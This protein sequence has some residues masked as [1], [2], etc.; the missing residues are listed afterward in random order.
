ML[1]LLGILTHLCT[2]NLC[3][4]HSDHEQITFLPILCALIQL[5][6]HYCVSGSFWLTFLSLP[7]SDIQW[8]FQFN[9]HKIRSTVIWLFFPPSGYSILARK[10]GGR[11][12]LCLE[13]YT[14]VT[15]SAHSKQY[16]HFL[17]AQNI[18]MTNHIA[19]MFS[20]QQCKLCSILYPTIQCIYLELPL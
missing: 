5:L 7:I 1:T 15:Y 17:Y 19:K 8:S 9:N 2:S 11:R 18:R 3:I 14:T 10:G 20:L 12:R 16:V 4:V 6:L 13:M